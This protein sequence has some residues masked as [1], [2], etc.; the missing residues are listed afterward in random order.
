MKVIGLLNK[1][2]EVRR[3][4]EVNDT[5]A[6]RLVSNKQAVYINDDSSINKAKNFLDMRM[7]GS[8][9]GKRSKYKESE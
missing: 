2:K 9:S 4:C 7:L 6:E 5:N 3:I 8:G 1:R